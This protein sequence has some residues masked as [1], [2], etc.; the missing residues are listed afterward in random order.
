MIGNRG[1]FFFRAVLNINEIPVIN[2]TRYW[3]TFLYAGQIYSSFFINSSLNLKDSNINLLI[4]HTF[5]RLTIEMINNVGRYL[6]IM[7]ILKILI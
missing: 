7:F 4:K 3:S 1:L 2:L 5:N 6:I